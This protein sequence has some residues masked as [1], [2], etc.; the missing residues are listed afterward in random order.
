MKLADASAFANAVVEQL[1]PWC[2]KIHVAGSIRRELQEVGDI[3]IV[4]LP[5]RDH[6]GPVEGWVKAVE[7]LGIMELGKKPKPIVQRR[8]VKVIL[9]WARGAQVDL[10]IPQAHDY[11][12]ILAIRTGSADYSH[13]VLAGCWTR[14][15]W[16]GTSEGLRRASQCEKKN[17]AWQLKPGV[18][19]PHLPPPFP[20]EESFFAFLHL[21]YVH[22]RTRFLPNR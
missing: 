2:E 11:G 19:E 22:P 20:D 18:R 21:A 4:A 8:M 7:C 13:K 5:K 12:R 10:F 16:V 6:E 15:G 14:L 1:R 17:N 9:P 3:E